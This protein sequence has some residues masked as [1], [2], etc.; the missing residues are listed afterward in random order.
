M[1]KY[2]AIQRAPIKKPEG[3]H[4][5]WRGLGCIIALIVP[6][7]SFVGA[8]LT[9]ELGVANNWPFIPYQLLGNVSL[10]A[11]LWNIAALTPVLAFI[12]AQPNLYAVLVFTVLYIVALAAI[13]VVLYA[14]IYRMV[15][16]SPYGPQDAP[17]LK[18]K[19]KRYKR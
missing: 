9:V 14:V 4:P 8:S 15:G 2:T 19:V 13:M 10:P 6:I 7:I 18:M 12:Q 1:G 11:Q 3:P 17:P 5:V 16:P